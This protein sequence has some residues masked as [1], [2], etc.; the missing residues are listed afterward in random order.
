[1][2]RGAKMWNL[3]ICENMIR[4]GR[5][6][7][8][9]MQE[10]RQNQKFSAPNTKMLYSFIWQTG[11]GRQASSEVLLQAKSKSRIKNGP[12]RTLSIYGGNHHNGKKKALINRVQVKTHKVSQSKYIIKF[13]V[14]LYMTDSMKVMLS[15]GH[16]YLG[17]SQVKLHKDKQGNREID[18]NLYNPLV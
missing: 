10:S 2:L 8:A 3:T 9:C 6:T 16:T 12:T 15:V 1:M 14:Y 4:V 7:P 5:A 13:L 11:R 17:Y 18:I